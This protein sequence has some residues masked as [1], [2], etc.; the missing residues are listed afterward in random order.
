MTNIRKISERIARCRHPEEVRNALSLIIKPRI[1]QSYPVDKK[2][3]V[4]IA[5]ILAVADVPALD[6]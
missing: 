4:S 6:K 5:D 1:E 2:R 3:G